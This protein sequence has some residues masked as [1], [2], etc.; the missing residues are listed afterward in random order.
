LDSKGTNERGKIPGTCVE[1]RGDERYA[2]SASWRTGASNGRADGTTSVQP[3]ATRHLEG[4][5]QP[6]RHA[7]DILQTI[8]DCCGA[9]MPTSVAGVE[10]TPLL[11]VSMR[12]TFPSAVERGS[13]VRP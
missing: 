9:P 8:L 1:V 10:Q 7:I 11:G 2:A 4:R 6:D 5:R 13:R 3:Q 12:Y